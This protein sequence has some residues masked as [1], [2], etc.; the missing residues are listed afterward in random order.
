[1]ALALAGAERA[2]GQTMTPSSLCV[3][4]N[5]SLFVT[6]HGW[7]PSER[8]EVMV[9]SLDYQSPIET[10]YADTNGDVYANITFRQNIYMQGPRAVQTYRFIGQSDTVTFHVWYQTYNPTNDWQALVTHISVEPLGSQWPDGW[11]QINTD[12]AVTPYNTYQ[13]QMAT[14]LSGPWIFVGFPSDS[15]DPYSWYS[16]GFQL[17]PAPQRFFRVADP[18]YPCPC[19]F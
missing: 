2:V 3:H 8:I 5:D 18:Y 4:T 7:S 13:F 14:N 12:A 17:P 11:M 10:I 6:G 1:M 19:D 9:P 15:D 16:E